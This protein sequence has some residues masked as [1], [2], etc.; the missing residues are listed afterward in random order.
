GLVV[1]QFAISIFLIIGIIT[2]NRQLRYIQNKSLGFDKE[3]VLI[4]QLPNRAAN[5]KIEVL[6]NE[7]LS[8]TDIT[9]VGASSNVPGER[10]PFLSVRVPGDDDQRIEQTE[11][12]EDDSFAMRTWSAGIDIVDALGL[13]I[14]EGR[15]F[16]KEFETDPQS[17]F[18][19]NEAAVKE[20]ELENPI[21]H[22]F[23]YLWGLDEPKKGKIVGVV[24]DF[25]YASLHHEVE[26]LVI[27]IF[28]Q[29]VRYLLVKMKTNDVQRTV[30]EVEKVWSANIPY[31]PMDYSFLDTSYDNLYKK[32][33]NTGAILGIFTI[34]AIII[35]VLGLFGLAAY[36]TEQ[37]TKE[38]G[39]RK[40]LGASIINIIGKLSKEF[41]LLVAIAN[42]LAWIPAII[43]LR[44]WLD[45]FA[46]RTNL[47]IWVFVVS[48][49]LSI[50]I[51][52]ITVSTKAWKSARAN[53]VDALKFE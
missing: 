32:E 39:V 45:T 29:Y 11:D 43:F 17:A 19:I 25:H 13:E 31:L 33:M 12:G 48:A 20:F 7:L 38:I 28:P 18:L 30:R 14:V 52:V 37:R 53:P 36:I 42:I 21:G 24:K 47:S 10:I 49:F 26:P 51:T 5:D 2:V 3:Q 41:I 46:F 9:S 23:E 34:L 16:S 15:D 8:Y 22:N 6:K 4:L 1:A 44:D 50:T 40:V 35:A 27:H